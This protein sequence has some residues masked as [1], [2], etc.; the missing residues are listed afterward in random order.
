[1]NRKDAKDA[2][3]FAKGLIFTGVYRNRHWWDFEAS[4][5]LRGFIG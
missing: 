3:D 4:W 1:M 5:S 2:E